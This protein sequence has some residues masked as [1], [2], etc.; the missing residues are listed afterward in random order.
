MAAK[1]P[2]RKVG[3][4][5][6]TALCSPSATPGLRRSFLFPNGAQIGSHR[7]VL[8]GSLAG[9]RGRRTSGEIRRP[10][11][12]RKIGV[13]V[14]RQRSAQDRSP[15]R[16]SRTAGA[17]ASPYTRKRHAWTA[18][19]PPPP[20][21]LKCQAA[22]DWQAGTA[23]LWPCTNR[24][25][26]CRPVRSFEPSVDGTAGADYDSP[27]AGPIALLGARRGFMLGVRASM[28]ARRRRR[29]LLSR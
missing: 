13:G 15:T 9:G 21:P 4:D 11:R 14:F 17:T 22:P 28:R 26:P 24:S 12:R 10:N 5:I 23:V 16:A 3:L 29:R 20:W 8:D 19:S 7:T 27:G 6:R 1:R 2:N 25:M 18:R